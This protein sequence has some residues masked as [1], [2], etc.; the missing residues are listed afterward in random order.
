M[1]TRA[2]WFTGRAFCASH[3]E[4]WHQLIAD[5]RADDVEKRVTE[6]GKE[7]RGARALWCAQQP[8]WAIDRSQA[9]ENAHT[10]SWAGPTLSLSITLYTLS[11]YVSLS[12]SLSLTLSLFY[13][14]LIFFHLFSLC[15]VETLESRVLTL[16]V[17]T[18]SGVCDQ[19]MDETHPSNDDRTRLWLPSHCRFPNPLCNSLSHGLSRFCF[20]PF[21]TLMFASAG[22]SE[23]SSLLE[24]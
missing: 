24:S 3:G 8:R 23:P 10:N 15:C 20:L 6:A 22:A 7:V 13:L 19:S 9:S 21:R 16:L 5:L 2:F 14:A 1:N 12:H 11:L 4:L 18:S 17:A